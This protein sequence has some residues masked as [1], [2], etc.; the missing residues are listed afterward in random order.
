[1]RAF[2]AAVFAALIVVPA[3]AH[4]SWINHQQ[5]RNA[6]G[7]WCCGEGDCFE[8]PDGAV[9]AAADGYHVKGSQVV[10]GKDAPYTEVVP[11]KEVQPSPDGH[12]WRCQRPDGSRRCFFGPP[13]G[14]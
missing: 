2:V 3:C 4:D 13:N 11:Y 12:F 5:M 8:L 14:F 10:N 7:E 6:A 1:M 9:V